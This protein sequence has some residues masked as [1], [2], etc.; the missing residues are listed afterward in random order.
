[1]VQ[2]AREAGAVIRTNCR[3]E[4][5]A[6]GLSHWEL[7]TGTGE[8]WTAKTLVG[9]DG[10]NSW[11]ARQLDMDKRTA[12]QGRSVGFQIRI[13]SADASDD[14]I[15]IH[16]FPGGYAGLVNIGGGI[17][18]L[19]LAIEK[20]LLPRA[21][22]KR[23]LLREQLPKNP[24]L[25]KILH[26][27]H[28]VGELRAAYPVYFAKRRSFGEAVVF[29]GDAARITEPVTGEGIYFALTS[30]ILAAKSIDEALRKGDL[31]ESFLCSYERACRRS[32]R[33]RVFVNSALRF[34]VYR[35]ALVNRIIHWSAM[36]NRFL[37]TAVDKICQ[38][39]TA[40]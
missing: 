10:R 1:L 25:K 8:N 19:G 37:A 17:W 11:L 4:R 9:A 40:L 24:F 16:L 30:G 6:K 26:G 27:C 14:R 39:A 23:F 3:V 12:E 20:H 21:D 7:Q 35:P 13:E 15:E 18:T 28:T 33:S 29:V 22:V 31:S 32:F 2:R 5:L 38:P 36:N 34:A